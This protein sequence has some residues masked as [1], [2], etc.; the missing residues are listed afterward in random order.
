MSAEERIVRVI[1]ADKSSE[2]STLR[3]AAYCRVST[4]EEDQL[5]SFTT[6]MHYYHDF[7]SQSDNMVLVDIYADEGITGTS[8]EKRNEFKRM[9]NDCRL[10]KIDRIYV[11][12]VSRFARNA[13]ECIESIRLLRDYGVSVFFENDRIDTLTL[14]SELILYVKSAFAQSEAL[15]TSKRVSTANKMR[16]EIGE[17]SICSAP[18]GFRAK[19]NELFTVPEEATIVREVYGMYLSGMGFLK[20]AQAL[21]R[22]YGTERS[23]R[24]LSAL[25]LRDGLQFDEAK[26]SVFNLAA[27]RYNCCVTDNGGALTDALKEYLAA[28]EPMTEIDTDILKTVISRFLIDESGIFYAEFVNGAV[29][30]NE[31]EGNCN[32]NG[33]S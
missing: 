14:N 21:N 29:I 26:K 1:K 7:I 18:Y 2:N 31:S 17:Y 6:Q 20:I 12:S 24:F 13:L 19:D 4:S 33:N 15:A 11:K 25:L 3:V 28:L 32:A 9:L 16:L 22:K 5:N 23:E 10:G 27:E 30:S 8:V